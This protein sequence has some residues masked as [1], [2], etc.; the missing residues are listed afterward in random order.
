MSIGLVVWLLH[1]I[2]VLIASQIAENATLRQAVEAIGSDP[3]LLAQVSYLCAIISSLNAGFHGTCPGCYP[4]VPPCPTL[5]DMH[6]LQCDSAGCPD[7]IPA[8]ITASAI[9]ASRVRIRVSAPP[10]LIPR[11]PRVLLAWPSARPCTW[12]TATRGE[13]LL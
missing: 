4:P 9:P 7:L 10:L 1:C 8:L 12:P 5:P 2:L 13:F 3:A 11:L 6:A